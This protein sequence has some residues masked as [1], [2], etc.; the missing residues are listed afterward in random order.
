MACGAYMA[1]LGPEGMKE[2]ASQCAAKAHYLAGKLSE[3][4]FPLKYEG[5]FFDE[6]V[7]ESPIPPKEVEKLLEKEGILSGL[8][9]EGG[10]LWCATEMNSR[11]D[12]DR[13]VS[14]LKGGMAHGTHI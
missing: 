6:F 3:I 1:A 8:P 5:P 7:T 2:A 10:I 11:E 4:G 12:M 13:L 9:L 14:L